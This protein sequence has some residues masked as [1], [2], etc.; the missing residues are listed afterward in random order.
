MAAEFEKGFSVREP[1]WHGLGEV[2][3]DYPGREEAM[4][5][6]G[7]RWTVDR[8]RIGM[9][10]DG[11]TVGAAPDGSEIATGPVQML[12]GYDALVRSDTGGILSV[13]KDTYTVVQNEQVWDL[14]D[15]L[16]A[17]PRVRYETAGTLK[18]GRVVWAMA[19]IEGDY[20]VAGDPTEH[21]PFLTVIN[22]HDGN[23]ALR[24]MRNMVRVVCQNT[25]NMA[26]AEA[27]GSGQLFSFRHTGDVMER[28]AEARAAIDSVSAEAQ[29]YIDMANELAKVKITAEGQRLFLERFIPSPS[30]ELVTDRAMAN[31]EEARSA[32]LSILRGETGTLTA[33]Q[34]RTG[35]GLFEAGI[36]RLD[37]LKP[38][39]SAE[40]RF[41]RAMIEPTGEKQYVLKLVREAAKVA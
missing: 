27:E 19:A 33:K 35:Y 28:V 30:A 4:T 1:M 5:L 34:G 23:G 15:A 21:K 7:H 25:V 41:N 36:E 20:R 13:M 22:W 39:R 32:V 8:R 40:S 29:A 17:D 24:A 10:P 37:Y 14:V 26:V 12:A 18:D 2:L 6:A 3:A 11:T 9:V 38:A 31:I 16:V